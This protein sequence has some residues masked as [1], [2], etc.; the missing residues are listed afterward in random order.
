MI[1]CTDI[2]E[3]CNYGSSALYCEG[4]T[5]EQIAL[6]VVPLDSLPASWWNWMWSKT[7]TASNCA[8]TAVGNILSELNNV[9]KGAGYTPDPLNQCQLYNAMVKIGR[10]IGTASLAGSIKSSSCNGYVC[11]YST[12]L[13]C[14]N[15]LGNVGN[16]TTTQKGNVVVAINELKSTYDCCISTINTCTASL[17]KAKAPNN[18]ASCNT[19][20]GVGNATV[21]GHVKLSDNYTSSAGAAACSI[22]ASSLAVYN[23]YNTLNK[24]KAP[25]NHASCNTTYGVGNATCYGHV[26]LSD[27]YDSSTCGAVANGVAA[28]QCAVYLAYSCACCCAYSC[29]VACAESTRA[30]NNH[31]SCNTTYGVGNATCYGHV[32]LSDAC[33]LTACS[34]TAVSQAALRLVSCCRCLHARSACYLQQVVTVCIPPTMWCRCACNC[35]CGSYVC[36]IRCCDVIFQTC[37]C[38]GSG[39]GRLLAYKA[40]DSVSASGRYITPLQCACC[41]SSTCCILYTAHSGIVPNIVTCRIY[42]NS[43]W[44][45]YAGPYSCGSN[46]PLVLVDSYNTNIVTCVGTLCF[47]LKYI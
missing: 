27:T 6:G 38:V 13:A 40:N 15:G 36:S 14:A 44:H 32:K 16:L 37:M 45:Y 4:P 8:R 2:P 12:G 31:A 30:P 25:N 22:G 3:V 33:V 23:T 26:K 21:Y 28:S 1:C 17:N 24:A 47:A 10:S 41:S 19:T 9:L 18:H 43:R 34:D 39:G 35:F 46:E 11:I 7:N 20:Y 42:S 29:A 5:E